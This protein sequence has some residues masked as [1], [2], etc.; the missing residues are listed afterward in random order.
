[1]KKLSTKNKHIKAP[2]IEFMN[3]AQNI[4]NT[5]SLAQGLPSEALPQCVI[6]EIVK[7]II[8]NDFNKYCP[9]KG[10][11]KLRKSLYKFIKKRYSKVQFQNEDNIMITCG[12]ME[13]LAAS[14]LTILDPKDEVI[15][16]APYYPSHVE[17][18]HMA[19]GIP[20]IVNLDQDY[21][22]DFENLESEITS[23]TKAIIICNPSNPTGKILTKKEIKKLTQIVKK[24]DLFVINDE[25]YNFLIHDNNEFHSLLNTN[26]N[27]NLITVF[28]FSKEFRISGLRVGYMLA[29]EKIIEHAMKIH[30]ILT[31]CSPTLSQMIAQILLDNRDMFKTDYV[32]SFT[33][34]R[35]ML[36]DHLNKYADLFSYN[37]PE[38]AYYLFIKYNLDIDSHTVAQRLL[39]EVKIITV[40][41]KGFGKI[42]ENHLRLSFAGDEIELLDATNKLI[43]W[44]KSCK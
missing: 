20:K 40:P 26:I 12:A 13:S 24:H 23:K 3:L 17:Q 6:D 30:D 25:T 22:I 15:I 41:G 8:Q 32:Q 28:S 33:K 42:G 16:F 43:N 19:G 44:F 10:L 1:M 31:I 18:V 29:D 37:I 2:I 34:K 39:K 11:P 21:Q 9:S 36:V 7:I 14:L 38:G 27:E 5:I 35:D 4:N